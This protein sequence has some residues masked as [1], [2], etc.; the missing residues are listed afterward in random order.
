MFVQTHGVVGRVQSLRVVGLR[1][2]A[3]R[4]GLQFLPCGQAAVSH[5]IVVATKPGGPLGHATEVAPGHGPI[6]SS[7]AVF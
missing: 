7:F 5:A 4:G 1:P 2:P 3:M 6:S